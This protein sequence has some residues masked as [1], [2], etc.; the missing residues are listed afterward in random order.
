M[1][2]IDIYRSGA[3]HE[4][5]ENKNH[6][7]GADPVIMII[8]ESADKLQIAKSFTGIP[9]GDLFTIPELI[10]QYVQNLGKKGLLSIH[11]LES[12]LSSIIGES[13]LPYLKIEK[14]KQGYVKALTDFIFNFRKTSV[15]DLQSA[16]EDFKDDPLTLK[17]KD[18]VK[19]YAEYEKRLP[20]YGFDL[21][22][23][24]EIFVQN[25]NA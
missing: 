24:L 1:A 12:I 10:G 21:K 8:P 15:N 23:G 7:L 22:S 5:I 4:F 19:I 3:W 14:Y 16:I 9:T 17:E 6:W 2:R 25:T 20:D 13:V 18:L 11:G